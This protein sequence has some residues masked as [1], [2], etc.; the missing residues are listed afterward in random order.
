VHDARVIVLKLGG[1]VLTSPVTLRRAVHE[2]YRWRREGYGVVAVVS[3]LAGATDALLAEA[4]ARGAERDPFAVAALLATGEGASAARLGSELARAGVP[5]CALSAH[6]AGIVAEGPPLDARPVELEARCIRAALARDEVAVVPG[7]VARDR[8]G[9]TVTLGRGGSDLSAV[10][11]ATRLSATR[12]R[13]VKDVDGLYER[14]PAAGG[15]RPARFERASWEDALATDGAIVQAKALACAR[16]SALTFELGSL[17]GPRPTTVGP[18]PSVWAEEHP[19]PRALRVVLAGLGTVGGGVWELARELPESLAVIG[20]VVRDPERPRAAVPRELVRGD[21]P[22]SLLRSADVLVEAIGGTGT[23][24]ELVERALSLGVDVV[25]ANKALVAGRGPYLRRL[26][27]AR[28]ATLSFSATVGGSLPVLERLTR[29][30]S[31][32]L[33][34]LRGV[35]NGTTN[36]VLDALAQGDSP[37]RAVE[38][39]RAL[40]LAEGDA[41]RDLSGRDAADKLAVVAQALG[42]EDLSPEEVAREE[43]VLAAPS[44]PGSRVLRQVAHLSLAGGARAAVRVETLDPLDP[45]AQV[46]GADNAVELAFADGSLELLRGAGAGRWPS[47]E[48]VL[49][50]LLSL[51]AARGERPARRRRHGPAA[52]VP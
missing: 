4:R 5:A 9:R 6:A 27:R 10:F 8:A 24:R 14:D 17:F 23:A 43:L 36:F 48:S 7:F 50:D 22:E 20:V 2:V 26:A 30:P 52:A 35:L 37:A 34:A 11:L 38:R 19:R 3:A 29:R 18:G 15:P 44:D 39:A 49:A 16:A 40:G 51:A 47:A 12:C 33:V 25:T 21:L 45:L 42:H 32:D 1:S 46:R 13:L 31:R 41:E 28:G